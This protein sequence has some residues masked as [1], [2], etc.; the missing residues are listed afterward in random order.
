MSK[1][2]NAVSQFTVSFCVGVKFE[3]EVNDKK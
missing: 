2:D 1:I 3:E